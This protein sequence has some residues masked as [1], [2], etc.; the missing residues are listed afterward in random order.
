M[1]KVIVSH[2][3][4]QMSMVSVS[5]FKKPYFPSG[6]V[7]RIF[8]RLREGFLRLT[9]IASNS[10]QSR[11]L[12]PSGALIALPKVK[13][14]SRRCYSK[15]QLEDEAVS[16]EEAFDAVGGTSTDKDKDSTQGEMACMKKRVLTRFFDSTKYVE[17]TDVGL[18]FGCPHDELPC[19]RQSPRRTHMCLGNLMS[20]VY[21]LKQCKPNQ[22]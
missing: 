16:C 5:F 21:L 12:L 14:C 20:V 4:E 2:S 10:A 17:A 11:G 1:R 7:W 8:F 3:T 9:S 18:P 22:L 15:V 13:K 6:G 19:A